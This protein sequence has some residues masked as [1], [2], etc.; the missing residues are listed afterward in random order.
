MEQIKKSGSLS[1]TAHNRIP[2]LLH[3]WA[4]RFCFLLLPI[5][6]QCTGSRASE[7]KPHLF[8][9]PV[10]GKSNSKATPHKDN[11]Q[12]TVQSTTKARQLKLTAAL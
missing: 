10:V 3:I 5:K 9:H 8:Q 2:V 6:T 4:F 12:I 1:D 7:G 11:N